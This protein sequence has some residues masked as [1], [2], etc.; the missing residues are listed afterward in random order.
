MLGAFTAVFVAEFLEDCMPCYYSHS[1]DILA[2]D[3]FAWRVGIFAEPAF[4]VTKL[5][6]FIQGAFTAMFIAEFLAHCKPYFYSPV[7]I[8]IQLISLF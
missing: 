4:G 3:D 6:R 5:C 8:A 1:V 2:L 7:S